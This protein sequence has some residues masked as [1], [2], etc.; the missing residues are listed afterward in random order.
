MRPRSLWS[1]WNSVAKQLRAARRVAVFTDFDGTL[2][3]IRRWPEDAVLSPRVRKTLKMLQKKAVLCG[4]VSGR[5]LPDLRSHA[6]VAGI[7]YVGSHGASFRAP[8]NR[9]FHLMNLKQ[10]RV[11]Q[12]ARRFL[13][14]ALRGVQAVWL[15][16]KSG[17]LAIHYRGAGPKARQRAR[18]AYDEVLR[19]VPGLESM[20]GKQIWELLPRGR[21]DKAAAIELLLK[22]Q[23]GPAWRKDFCIVYLGD[24]LTDESV[25]KHLQGISVAV[26]KRSRTAARYFVETP[27]DVRKFLL[28]LGRVL[29]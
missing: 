20:R 19:R 3:R 12:R 8:D 9:E 16:E 24:D 6:G 2:T 13:E 17:A 18:A 1:S 25:F 27:G 23:G 11:M 26:G 5:S 22:K 14:G 7:W 29:P 10:R 4:I 15:E 28:R 21:M